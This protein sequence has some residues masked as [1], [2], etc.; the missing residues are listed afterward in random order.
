M[1]DCLANRYQLCGVQVMT[2]A[3]PWH[4]RLLQMGADHMASLRQQFM[5]GYPCPEHGP[6]EHFPHARLI[7]IKKSLAAL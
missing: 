7:M 5:A 6:L 4:A 1:T 2:E 3:G